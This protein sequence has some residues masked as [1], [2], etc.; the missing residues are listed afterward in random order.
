MDLPFAGAMADSPIQPVAPGLE[1][2]CLPSTPAAALFWGVNSAA[3]FDFAATARST[4]P[5]RFRLASTSRS[6]IASRFTISAAFGLG[7]ASSFHRTSIFAAEH[8]ITHCPTTRSREC[9]SSLK[10]TSGSVP[11]RLSG[12]A[13]E[14]GKGRSLAL[15]RSYRRTFLLGRSS[16]AIRRVS[17]RI[18]FSETAQSASIKKL[19]SSPAR[20]AA[21]K[22]VAHHR[23]DPP[24]SPWT[25]RRSHHAR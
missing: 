6:P 18:V 13:F 25:A 22:T 12:R 1:A 8:T 10:T 5:G 15:G 2:R 14:S 9:R 16:P 11:A 20:T 4:F 23:R 24:S 3:L 19:P 21:R 17:S 7:T